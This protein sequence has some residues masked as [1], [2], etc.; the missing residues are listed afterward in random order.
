MTQPRYNYN[1]SQD[2]VHLQTKYSLFKR[3]ANILFS[4]SF[5]KG[6]EE[7]TMKRA[8]ELL[9]ERNDCLRLKM[10]K[11]G[12][13]NLQYFRE[14]YVIGDIP[15][16]SFS[17]YGQIDKFVNKFR[18]RAIN[19]YKGETF[20]PVFVTG[21]IGEKMLFIKIS[22]LVAD[23]Y[24][25]GVL[26]N[27][28]F[29][30]Y[31]A[32]SGGGELPAAPGSFEEVLKKDNQYRNNDAATEKDRAFFKEYYEVRHPQIPQY[33]GIHGNNSDRWLKIKRKGYKSLPYLFVNCDTKGYGFVI[34]AAITEKAIEWCKESSMSMNTFFF[35]TCAI[36]CSLKN[37]KAP[38]QLPLELMN[39]RGTVADKKAAGTKVQSLS[40]YT[41]V[42][43][44]SSFMEN[45]MLL[46]QDQSELYRHTKLTFLEIQ[47]IQH[48]LWDYSMM[49]QLT[50]F[51]F[52]FIPVAIQPGV[53][54]QLYSNGKGALPCYMALM[55]NINTNEI[56]AMYD[57]QT[58]M[59]GT[60][61]M[62]DFQNTY[63]KVIETVLAQP[64]TP[65]NELF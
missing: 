53:K 27:D 3:V 40:V 5:E 36:A 42:D 29:Q 38:Y 43:Y 15:S 21:P 33:L 17:E 50:N 44:S 46:F 56:H 16:Y 10:E 11:K 18:K 4:V 54:L 32:L 48:K 31:N 57:I 58:K 1:Y 14:K 52:S 45:V 2:I 62:I 63:I 12:K 22:H 28:L 24:G 59:C 35:Y 34:P 41:T 65:L 8:L 47:D 61:Q 60:E 55:H 19:V 37:D 13:E 64:E 7:G 39:C 20:K 9:V 30:I 51:C 25:I 49:S 26:V 23:T 6:F